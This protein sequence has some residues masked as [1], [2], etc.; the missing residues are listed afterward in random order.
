LSEFVLDARRE[1]AAAVEVRHFGPPSLL[2]QRL[3]A[4]GFLAQEH[5]D[6]LRVFVR[7]GLPLG[8]DLLAPNNWC[9]LPGAEDI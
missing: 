9:L 5:Q 6:G 3:H 8:E 2:T 4:F 1:G 7:A